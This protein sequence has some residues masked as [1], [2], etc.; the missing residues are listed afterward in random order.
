MVKVVEHKG[1]TLI[2][3]VIAVAIFLTIVT[4]AFSS[5]SQYYKAKVI[6]DQELRLQ[7]NFIVVVD[8]ISN[9]FKNASFVNNI[10]IT[11]PDTEAMIEATESNPLTFYNSNGTEVSYY[12]KQNDDKSYAVYKVENGIPEAI[13]ESLYQKTT[14]YFIRYG[15]GLVLTITGQFTDFRGEERISFTSLVYPENTQQ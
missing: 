3:M 12:A 1:F 4:I 10:L 14:L 2:E 13:T 11:S 6:Y 15:N 7:S 5:L 8:K 9:D